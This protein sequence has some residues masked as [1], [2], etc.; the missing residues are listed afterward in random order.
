[1]GQETRVIALGFFDGVHLGHG[2]LL[3]RVAERARELDALPTALTFDRSP[4]SLV[5]TDT[6]ALLTDPKDRAELMREL[7]GIREVDVLPFD[8]TMM[9]MPWERFV[10]EVLARRFHA[11]HVVAGH[12]YHF[13]YKGQGDPEK[14]RHLC[15]ELGIGCDIIGRVELDGVTISSTY[16][17]G[18]IAE[19][20]AEQARRFLGHP[21]MMSGTVVAGQ[22]VGRTMGIPTANLV[23]PQDVLPPA[24]GVY[25][26]RVRVGS[27]YYAAVTNVGVRPTMGDGRGLTVEPWILDFAGDL[28][29]KDIRVEFY[30]RLRG[31]RKFD[32][33][34]ELKAEIFRNAEQT[35]AYFEKDI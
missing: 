8:R 2:A 7:Y 13:G 22:Q 11:V 20:D 3:R 27:E 23:I 28:Y 12:D 17:R 19:G 9:E 31:E 29:G 18:L 32:S 4:K 1:M 14:L 30:H 10:T 25:A 35:R 6:I 5:R 24:K 33:L 21:H 15:G 34:E 16:I 26:T